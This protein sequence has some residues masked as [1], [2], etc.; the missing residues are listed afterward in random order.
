MTAEIFDLAVVGHFSMD[1]I[2]LPSQSQSCSVLGGSVAYV[3]LVARRLGASVSVISKVGSDF[4]EPYD[5]LLRRE[6]VDVSFVKCVRNELTT[7]FELSYSED[8]SDKNSSFETQ[9]F[10][11]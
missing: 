6:G 3:S 5:E 7:S 4:P 1:S 8:L 9:R 11:N 10:S 2:I